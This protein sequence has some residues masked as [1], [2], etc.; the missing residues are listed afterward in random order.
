MSQTLVTQETPSG[1]FQ[2]FAEHEVRKFLGIR[3]ASAPVGGLRFHPPQPMPAA[4]A[5]VDATRFGNRNLQVGVPEEVFA[6][7]EVQGDESEDCLFLNIYTPDSAPGPKP[8]LVWIHGGAFMCGSGNDYDASTFARQNDVVVVTINYRLGIFG[9]LNLQTLGPDYAGSPNLGIQDQIAALEW[10]KTNIGS[11]GGDAGNVTIFGESAGAASVLALFGAPGAAGLFHKGMA[12]SGA[13]T[14]APPMD[15]LSAIKAVLG[16]NTDEDCLDLL[17]SMPAD[18]LSLLQQTSGIYVGP[19]LD[20]VVLTRPA[21]EAIKDGGAAGIPF[22]SGTTRDEGSMLAEPFAA[23]EEIGT[24]MVFALAASIGRDDGAAYRAFLDETVAGGTVVDKVDRAWFD[25][26]RASALRVAATASEHGAGGWVY[27]F[28]LETDHSLGIAH[29]ADVPF[30]FN[31]MQEG[32][33]RLYVHPPTPENQELAV[34]WSGTIAEF[35]RSGTPNGHGL[36]DW[37]R[38]QPDSFDTLNFAREPTIVANPDGDAML[39]MYG[40]IRR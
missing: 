23:T 11:F 29:F 10:V 21:C 35:A 40:V 5:P 4:S 19:S 30:T 12:F 36:P 39:S 13:E 26:F 15:Q 37:P 38:Y 25:T 1:T 2:G 34:R 7:L 9:F 16:C 14:L 28:E 24:L 6:D 31:W 27:N 20:G 32:N 18:E 3:Y 22:L 17:K 8:V 33:E